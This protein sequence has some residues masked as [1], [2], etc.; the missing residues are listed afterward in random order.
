[1]VG[2][3]WG[4][5]AALSTLVGS[6]P[7]SF[8]MPMVIVQH[9]RRDAGSLLAE[10]LQDRSSLGVSEIEH[11]EPIEPGHVYV[12]PPDYHLLVEESQFSLS[13]EGAVRFSRPS[14]D[15]TFN[16]A[17]DSHGPCVTGIVLT[18][19]NEDGAIGLRHIVDRGG[20]AIVQDPRTAEV[21]TMPDAAIRLVPSAAVLPV[22][23]MA[24]HL[25]A[26]RTQGDRERAAR[27][28][29]RWTGRGDADLFGSAS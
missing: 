3:S 27:A 6:L 13:T 17:A 14:I 4:G 18:G 26:H 1:V 5:L 11:G 7:E 24:A 2:A 12:A 9:R 20:T 8:D 16:S 15:V 23:A 22:D 21:R 29:D 19:A 25:L 10:L 28:R